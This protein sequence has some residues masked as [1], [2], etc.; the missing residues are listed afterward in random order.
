MESE[1][2]LVLELEALLAPSER[3]AA[4]AYAQAQEVFADRNFL[5]SNGVAPQDLPPEYTHQEKTE[6]LSIFLEQP[7]A[8]LAP[9]TSGAAKALEKLLKK[10]DYNLPNATNKMRQYLIFKMFELA[11]SEDPKL[12]IKA[13]EML[14]K[15]SEIGL[16]STKIELTT[17]DKPTNELETE[18][19]TLLTTYSL[20][21]LSALKEVKQE[22]AELTDEELRGER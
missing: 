10:F 19:S 21:D 3:G 8:P 9:T 6:A 7:D 12:A 5:T 13:L 18:L 14:G 2:D 15:V 4:S 20:G 22:R 16:F 11:E 1:L 17:T